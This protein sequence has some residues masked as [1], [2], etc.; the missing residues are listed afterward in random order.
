MLL[1]SLVCLNNLTGQAVNPLIVNFPPSVYASDQYMSSPQN[2][3]VVQDR[4]GRIIMA[5]ASG[6]LVF[7]GDKWDAVPNTQNKLYYKFA[8]DAEGKVF[9]G[10]V[11][12]CGYLSADSIGGTEFTSIREEIPDSAR[13]FGRITRVVEHAGNIWFLSKDYLFRWDGKK[14]AVWDESDDFVRIFAEDGELF[15][16]TTGSILQFIDGRFAKINLPELTRFGEIRA[17]FPFPDHRYGDPS[18]MIILREGDVLEFREGIFSEISTDLPSMSIFNATRLPSREILVGTNGAGMAVLDSSGNFQYV[19]GEESGLQQGQVVF[20]YRDR[21]NAIW[22]AL[23]LGASRIEYAS[24]IRLLD[25]RDGVLDFVLC[26]HFEGDELHVGTIRGWYSSALDGNPRKEV[27]FNPEPGITSEVYDIF[28]WRDGVIAIAY[29]GIFYKEGNGPPQKVI[30]SDG[31]AGGIQSH[32][33]PDQLYVATTGNEVLQIRF[34]DGA[35]EQSGAVDSLPHLGNNLADSPDSRYLW[36][37]YDGIS[38]IDLTLPPGHPDRVFTLDSTHGFDASLG[39][40]EVRT[41]QNRIVFG[42]E[43][44]ILRFDVDQNRLVPDSTFGTSFSDGSRIAYNLTETRAGD[45]WVTTDF[46]TGILRKQPDG[47]FVYDSLPIIRAPI[48]D[49]FSIYEDPTGIVW[50]GG[51]EALVR[52]DPKIE[53]NYR[54]P[55]HCLIRHV[56]LND[57]STIF[58]GAYTDANGL[59]TTQ[60][61]EHYV[62]RL[63]YAYNHLK[64]EY[65]ALFYDYPKKLRYSVMLEGQDASWSEWSVEKAREY[66]NLAEG[67]YTFK[68][69][70][71]NIYGTISEVAEYKFVIFA[72]WYR[73]FWAY[74]GY[75]ALAGLVV[76]AIVRLRTQRLREQKRRLEGIVAERTEE[77]RQQVLILEK[78]KETIAQEMQKSDALLLN[79]LPK[80]TAAELKNH[81]KAQPRYFDQVTVMFTDFKDFTKISEML[82]PEELVREIDFCFRRFD[83]IVDRHGLEK[84]KTIGDAYMCAGGLPIANASHPVDILRAALE[85]RDFMRELKTERDARGEGTFE[86]RLGIHT[87]PVVAGIVGLNKFQY[88]I[89]GDTVNTASRMESSAAVGQVNIS[90]ATYSLVKDHFQ[91]TPRGKIAVK[92]KGEIGMYYVEREIMLSN[93]S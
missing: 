40:V 18:L 9:S 67:T 33:D 70:A 20:K 93:N 71:R 49:V 80:E 75:A 92:N 73:T 7:D 37:T 82:T 65:A 10:G 36:A 21:E 88:D 43:K 46:Q 5:N 25:E 2:F 12:D 89:W 56:T 8:V 15:A 6:I 11:D 41:L 13:D 59:P 42:T 77:I 51:V 44:G 63:P 48:S 55:Y 52:Y 31:V 32:I 74:L 26:T 90:E 34:R 76:V 81:G 87:G 53:K 84:I 85:I 60:Q 66:T 72:P 91:C 28:S 29:G 35:W 78:Q 47:R 54:L 68:V 39:F 83:E 45:V 3:C 58:R 16:T 1:L 79:I 57:D 64:F 19:L 62:H 24:P 38:R 50:F 4:I 22:T 14:I 69:K 17:I 61:P 23:F 86:L 30:S 27:K